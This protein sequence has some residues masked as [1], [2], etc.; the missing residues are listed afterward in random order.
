MCCDFFSCLRVWLLVEKPDGWL[1][2]L[3][4]L[5]CG[6]AVQ[7]GVLHVQVLEHQPVVSPLDVNLG[8]Y[9]T[10]KGRCHEIFNY[11]FFYESVSPKPLSRFEFFRKFAEIFTAPGAPQVPLT[12]VANETNLQSEKF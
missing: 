7:L 4:V 11:R 8:R 12:L 6:Q 3:A 2:D 1:P 10:L 9:F 5:L